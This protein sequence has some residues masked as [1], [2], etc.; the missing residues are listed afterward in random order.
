MVNP[1]PVIFFGRVSI[2][3]VTGPAR[4]GINLVDSGLQHRRHRSAAEEWTG[5]Q[6]NSNNFF[7]AAY[8]Y[9]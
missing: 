7:E 8:F 2:V 6:A 3:S 1:A 4:G 5:S 9:S